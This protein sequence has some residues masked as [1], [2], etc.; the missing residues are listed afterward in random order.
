[1]QKMLTQF[2]HKIG[3]KVYEF[4]CDPTSPIEHVKEALFQFSK[5]VGAIEDAIKAQKAKEA[6]PITDEVKN[7]EAA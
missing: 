2:E 5:Y 4:I 3:D 7:S 1:M 6:L